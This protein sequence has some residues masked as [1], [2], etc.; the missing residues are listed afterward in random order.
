MVDPVARPDGMSFDTGGA[1]G[2]D[3]ASVGSGYVAPDALDS[4]VTLEA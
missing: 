2:A 1:G 4:E 3:D